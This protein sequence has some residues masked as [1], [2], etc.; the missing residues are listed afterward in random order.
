MYTQSENLVTI[1]EQAYKSMHEL[2]IPKD[3]EASDKVGKLA[4]TVHTSKEKVEKATFDLRM[5][6]AKLQLKL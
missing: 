6:I 2:N 4:T 1:I 5:Q 3:T